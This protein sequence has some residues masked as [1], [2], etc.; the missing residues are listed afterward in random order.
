M[1]Y[2]SKAYLSLA[3]DPEI[4]GIV[5]NLGT[6]FCDHFDMEGLKVL[7]DIVTSTLTP[8][9]PSTAE[10]KTVKWVEDTDNSLEPFKVALA[11]RLP[12]HEEVYKACIFASNCRYLV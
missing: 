11:A 1:W 5:V 10:R 7:K 4:N 8:T 2:R 12:M 6:E 3:L 9:D